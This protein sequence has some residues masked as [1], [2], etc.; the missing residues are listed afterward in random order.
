MGAFYV[1]MLSH[2]HIS[3]APAH[4]RELRSGAVTQGER[5]VHGDCFNHLAGAPETQAE[6]LSSAVPALI[7]AIRDLVERSKVVWRG[8]EVGVFVVAT[9]LQHRAYRRQKRGLSG[10]VLTDQQRQ[11][12]QARSL[13]LPKA[14]GIPAGLSSW[15]GR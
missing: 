6:R 7:L 5:G 14:N 10:A 11:R 15:S 1:A 3:G 13:L 9:D 8:T 2:P 4:G 12:R